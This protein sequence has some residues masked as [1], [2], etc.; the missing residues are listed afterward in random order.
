MLYAL[1][2]LYGVSPGQAMPTAPPTLTLLAPVTLDEPPVA[3]AAPLLA[4][5]PESFANESGPPQPAPVEDEESCIFSRPCLA[6]QTGLNFV[7]SSG[8]GRFNIIDW[9]SQPNGDRFWQ[10]SRWSACEDVQLHTGI[11]FNIH[12]W[13]GP[14]PRGKEPVPHLPPQLFDLYLDMTWAQRWGPRLTSE[15]RFR[16]GMYTD[17]NT[18]PPDSFRMP[19]EAVALF[20][21][22][23]DL[24]LIGG[25]EYLQRND[26]KLLPVAGV[27][28]QPT[29]RWQLGLVFPRPKVAFELSTTQH[30]WGYLAAEYGGGR[31]TYDNPAGDDDRVEYSDYRVTFGIE[32]RDILAQSCSSFLEMG[33]VF[34]RH[35]RFADPPAHFEPEPAWMIR[36][37]S[38]W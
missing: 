34:E 35:L 12:W 19:G 6:S 25:V 37:G 13:S 9:E 10:R 20:Q 26:I 36:F 29:P 11:G 18:T 4:A 15:F 7:F 14:A 17:F 2:L 32:W 3:A 27:L 8:P 24:H 21:V 28:W 31:W 30:V 1:C 5:P 38:V 33:Y 16:P 23:P 22:D